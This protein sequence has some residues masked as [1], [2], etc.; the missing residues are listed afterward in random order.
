[1]QNITLV[2]VK[3]LYQLGWCPCIEFL[4]QLLQNKIFDV[5]IVDEASQCGF[6]G[7]PLYYL[8]KK[9]LVVGDDKQITPEA[10]GIPLDIVNRLK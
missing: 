1:M 9:I 10:V 2:F 4:R 8:A 6:E 5:V 3:M 7:I